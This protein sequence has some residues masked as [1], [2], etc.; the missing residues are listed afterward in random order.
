MAHGSDKSGRRWENN[1]RGFAGDPYCALGVDLH[2]VRVP[3]LP[4]YGALE[5]SSVFVVGRVCG[6]PLHRES[7]A[8]TQPGGAAGGEADAA[9]TC[10][11]GTHFESQCALE[12]FFEWRMQ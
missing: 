12:V 6:F 9:G 4:A 7:H 10:K 5:A 8:I 1:K 3:F 2:K 11:I